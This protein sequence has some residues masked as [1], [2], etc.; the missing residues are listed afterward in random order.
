MLNF[1]NSKYEGFHLAV[2]LAFWKYLDW[3]TV[4]DQA[5]TGKRKSPDCVDSECEL[6][7]WFRLRV[8]I[9]KS[10]REQARLVNSRVI[11]IHLVSGESF[12]QDLEAPADYKN[13]L[14][15]LE[16]NINRTKRDD[17]FESSLGQLIIF[18]LK[19]PFLLIL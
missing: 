12:I 11:T 15:S 18:F 3:S 4:Q 16:V 7:V 1:V 17:Q 9:K 2:N 19:N 6:G 10:W 5:Q 14:V 8:R 13:R